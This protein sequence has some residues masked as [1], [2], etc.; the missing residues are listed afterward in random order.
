VTGGAWKADLASRSTHLCRTGGD[1]Q[2]RWVEG[3][4]RLIKVFSTNIFLF[5][6]IYDEKKGG[7]EDLRSTSDESLSSYVSMA[8][9]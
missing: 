7:L 8:S 2:D 5:F 1:V 4:D 9:L 6:W 3:F